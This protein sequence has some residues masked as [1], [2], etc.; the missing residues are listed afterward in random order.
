MEP[1]L[2]KP[3]PSEKLLFVARSPE[4]TLD[5][6]ENGE[7]TLILSSTPTMT[8][9]ADRPNHDA[10]TTTTADALAAFGWK[11]DDDDLGDEPPNAVLTGNELTDAVVI[12]LLTAGLDGDALIFT[13][14]AVNDVPAA[15]RNVEVTHADLFIDDVRPTIIGTPA[16]SQSGIG[17]CGLHPMGIFWVKWEYLLMPDGTRGANVYGKNTYKDNTNGWYV[18][19]W[20]SGTL[21]T[22]TPELKLFNS[23]L[24]DLSDPELDKPRLGM[25]N[26]SDN[27]TFQ[28]DPESGKVT[29]GA[30]CNGTDY[31]LPFVTG[32][33][34]Y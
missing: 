26:G 4:A 10:G 1:V 8:W 25:W 20:W 21:T 7:G 5:L 22:A 14:K 13:V 16:A 19:K 34:P 23:Y 31:G 29:A 6:D 3:N 27:K 32:T 15:E 28:L 18:S 9:F 33:P 12:E 17:L 30:N 24:G 11:A 2:T